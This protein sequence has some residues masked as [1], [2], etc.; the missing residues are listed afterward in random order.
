[1]LPDDGDIVLR[2]AVTMPIPLLTASARFESSAKR[3]ENDG[4]LA[5]T[6]ARLI[7]IFCIIC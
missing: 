6:G 1:M 5:H 3:D 2:G 4:F 7:D